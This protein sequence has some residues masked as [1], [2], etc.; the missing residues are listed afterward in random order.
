M[1]AQ[2]QQRLPPAEVERLARTL[3]MVFPQEVVT[4]P[5]SNNQRESLTQ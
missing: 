1:L 4:F 2:G 5:E 3:G